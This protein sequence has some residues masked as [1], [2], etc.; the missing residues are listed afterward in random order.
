VSWI[1][2]GRAEAAAHQER[3]IPRERERR[4]ERKLREK[5]AARKRRELHGDKE[6]FPFSGLVSLPEHVE[7]KVV[8]AV[9]LALFHPAG[10]KILSSQ[11]HRGDFRGLPIGTMERVERKCRKLGRRRLV[12]FWPPLAV[13]TT[14]NMAKRR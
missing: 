13:F 11:G 9:S 8:A 10:A 7:S 2:T 12:I 3:N 6:S 5:E 14:R 4:V 1:A